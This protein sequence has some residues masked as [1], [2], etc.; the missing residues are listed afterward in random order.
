MKRIV[1]SLLI[2]ISFFGA[3]YFKNYNGTVIPYPTLWY[4]F[5]TVLGLLGVWLIYTSLK[6]VKTVVEQHINTKI[7]KFKSTAERIELD[8]DKCEFKSGSFSQEVEDSDI[9]PIEIMAE[10]SLGSMSNT[11]MAENV[12]RSYLV[13]A[14]TLNGDSYKFIS[15]SFPMDQTTLKFHVLKHNVILYVD[16]FDRKKYMFDV[17]R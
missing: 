2:I 9:S 6:K 10:G 4:L 8:L 13:Y 16:R 11:T 12:I 15:H 5:F 7:E 14:D 1:G 3:L 17:K